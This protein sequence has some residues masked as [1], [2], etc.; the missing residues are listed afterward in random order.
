MKN[1]LSK[2]FFLS[3]IL[4]ILII[5]TTCN[6]LEK[7]ML[8]STDEATNVLTNSAD[9][10]GQII[11]LGNGATQHGHYYGKSANPSVDHTTLGAPSS[12]TGFTSQITNL[13]AG[14]RYYFK[15]YITDGE[16]TVYGKEKSFTTLAASAP[17]LSTTAITAITLTTATSG[18][19][20]TSD[21]GAPVTARGVCWNTATGPSISNSKTNDGSGT[22]AFTSN[23][24]GLNA[25]TIYYIKAYATN[26]AGTTYGNEITFT[27]TAASI[28][29]VTTTTVSGISFNSALGGG[30]VTSDGGS[31]ILEKGVCWGTSSG[32]TISNSKTAIGTGTGNF[33]SSIEGLSPVTKYYVRA[34]ATNLVGTAY[35]TEV[36]FTT[37]A[38]PVQL[39]VLT[40]VSPGNVT[41]I[42]ATS[43]GN[44][45]SDG[46]STITSRG[47]CWNGDGS[48]TLGGN[49]TNDGNGS[50]TFASAITGLSPTTKYYVRAYAV[51]SVG[52]AYGT[53]YN[54]TTLSASSAVLTTS[55]ATSITQ[56]TANSGGNITSDG[57]STIT[58]RGV[59]WSKNQNPTLADSYTTN[60][61]GTG[62]FNS[63][64]TSLS[65]GKTYFVRAYA[66]N[67]TGTTYGNQV[68]FLTASDIPKVT[69]SS[70]GTVTATTADVGGE[71]LDNNGSTVTTRGVCY[72]TIGSPAITDNIKS[73]S[74]SIGTFNLTITGLTP[75]T[76]YYIRAFATNAV[77]TAYGSQVMLVTPATTPTLT[78]TAVTSVTT[79][80]ASS[81]GS[82][83]SDGGST[84][85][86]KGVC[87]G[88]LSGPVSDGTNQTTDGGGSSNYT[89]AITGLLPN[90]NYFLR[91]YATNSKGTSYGN[92]VPFKTNAVAVIVPT[93]STITYSNITQ[94]TA[95]S[96]GN[97][98]SNGGE[99]ITASG[100]CWGTST[101]PV[102]TGNHTTDGSSTG[103]YTSSITGM[104][105]NTHYYVRA[106][107]TNSA[108]TGYGNEINFFTLPDAPTVT[109]VAASSVTS[110]SAILHGTVNANS[111]SS[112]VSFEHGTSTTYSLSTVASESPVTGTSNTSVSASISGLSPGTTYHYRVKAVNAGGTSYGSDMTF[113]APAMLADIDGNNYGTVIIGAQVWMKENLKVTHYRNGD[114]IPEVID[115]P[116][117]V[118]LTSGAY[119]NYNNDA[120]QVPTYGRLYNYFSTIDNRNLC[121]TGW[122]VPT[123][124]EIVIM[125]DFLGGTSIAG[126][127]IKEAGTIHWNS[128]NTGATNESE[129]TFL[130]GGGRWSGTYYNIGSEGGLWTSTQ[131]TSSTSWGR[132]LSATTTS[133]NT[134]TNGKDAGLSVRCLKGEGGVLPSVSTATVNRISLTSVSSGGNVTSSGN[135]TVTAKGVCWSTSTGPTISDSHSIDGTGTGVFTSSI[136]DLPI[137]KIYYL[138]AYATNSVGTAYGNEVIFN[139]FSLA[140]GVNYQGGIIAYILQS[141][142]PGYAVGQT[143]GL[144][145]A[146]SDQSTGA[147]WGCYSTTITGADGT[148]IGTGNQNTTDIVAGCSTAGIAAR[149]CD[150]LTLG[151]Y[152]DWYLP[153]KDELNKLYLEKTVIG[154]FDT[155][156]GYLSSTEFDSAK[157]WGQDFNLGIQDVLF[158][159]NLYHVRAV[160]SF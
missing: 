133:A 107:A 46:G 1:N 149:L 139:T 58:A 77:G 157:A 113:T 155:F 51:N 11:D 28:P 132:Y 25:G 153:S 96:G 134:G 24:T 68:S 71:V 34:Y 150:A 152:S 31:S 43:G 14:T 145:A 151:G 5:V 73:E 148:L 119:C 29:T 59:C 64:L 75:A 108:G 48:P 110:Y 117:W 86:I 53:E 23:L 50:G 30:N 127:K 158:K 92:E 115:G 7:T 129:F 39:P 94:T 76:N 109:S 140:V 114:L 18:G 62:L 130:P 90:T 57:G 16:E 79:T 135:S 70:V 160:R 21:G 91:A 93:L 38:A 84:I 63:Q 66:T 55:S 15:A 147:L 22:G 42:S 81:G 20:I 144:I 4:L 8:V 95:T 120:G 97:I 12:L 143:H 19:N 138:R 141:G 56:T 47:V 83:T 69:T 9:L 100:V 103:S 128:P 137:D 2:L 65:P 124:A 118:G 82:I 41:S 146:T 33:G 10:P 80:T 27:T 6:K 156:N 131:E 123:D 125:T 45:T 102:S 154:G 89:S 52:T 36:S 3:G 106:Y 78:T 111:A 35:G 13:E 54:F 104:T 32:P 87:W 112:V 26:S 37:S 126:G 85:L 67:S 159:S 44:I 61:F 49:S 88:T 72:N 74:G 142:D 40:T 60:D 121:P 98:T 105:A 17:T 101:N 99:T 136:S 116:T 122:H